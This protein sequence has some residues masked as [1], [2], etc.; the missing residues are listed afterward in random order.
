MSFDRQMEVSE[1]LIRAWNGA[2]DGR[3]KMAVC[4]PTI[5]PEEKLAGAALAEVKREAGA[6]RDLSRRQHVLFLQDG[7]TRGTVKYANDV[8][9]LLGSTS[10][11]RTRPI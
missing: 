5:S 8:L 11:S 4:F 1:S 3:I 7:H 10:S 6:A 2:A 9:Y